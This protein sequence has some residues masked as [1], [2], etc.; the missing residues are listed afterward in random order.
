MTSRP[1]R[2]TVAGRAYLDLQNLARRQ[3]RPTDELHQMYALEGFLARLAISSYAGQLILKGGVLLAAYEARRPTRDVDLQAR[4]LPDQATEALSTARHI[5]ALPVDDGLSFDTGNATAHAIRDTEAYSGV[6]VTLTAQLATARLTFH[7]DMSTGDPIWPAP[8]IITLPRLLHGHIRISGYPLSMVHAEKLVTA[9]QRGTANT[10]WRDFADI[11]LLAARHNI[12]GDELQSAITRVAA[13]RRTRLAPLRGI[14]DGYP[15]IAQ[16][17][18]A[19][20]RRGQRLDDRLPSQFAD[21]LGHVIIFADPVLAGTVT[22]ATWN[23][24][25][26]QW[27]P[28]PASR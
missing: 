14:L 9:V 10:R 20:W 22:D 3:G 17:R 1:T 18:W 25:Q 2:A 7:V 11:Y 16:P 27:H 24:A 12:P 4:R 6:R 15:A 23:A 21:V 13:H 28:A 26:Q 8:Q 5:A 19:A